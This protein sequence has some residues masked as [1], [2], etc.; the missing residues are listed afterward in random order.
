EQHPDVPTKSGVMM[1]LGETKEEIVEVLKDL[2]AHGVSMLTL[3]Q[4][5]APSRHHL[6]VERYVPPAEFDELKEIALE[7]GFTH[8]ACGPFVRSSY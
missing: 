1:G 3:G 4:Y 6:P 2:R 5:L 8:A 7:L